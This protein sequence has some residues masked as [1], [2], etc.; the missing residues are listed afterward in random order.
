MGTKAQSSD[1]NPKKPHEW[2]GY[3]LGITVGTLGRNSIE[4]AL[5]VAC[6]FYW[7]DQSELGFLMVIALSL[8]TIAFRQK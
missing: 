7:Q 6:V 4:I 1:Y 3:Y 2:A 5:T 8:I